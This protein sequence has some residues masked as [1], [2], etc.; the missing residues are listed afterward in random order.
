MNHPAFPFSRLPAPRSLLAHMPGIASGTNKMR[1]ISTRLACCFIVSMLAMLALL[2]PPAVHAQS[3]VT[4]CTEEALR[5]AIL[6]AIDADGL[7]VFDCDGIITLTNSISI[8]NENPGIPIELTF[9]AADHGVTISSLTGDNATNAVRLFFIAT[10]ASVEFINITF[11]N[12]RSTNGGAIYN[13][14]TNTFSSCVFSNNLATGTNGASAR[15]GSTNSSA[16]VGRDGSDGALGQAASGGAI[17]NWGTII[18][19]DCAFLTNS[20]IGG[21]GGDG[22]NAGAGRSLG[23]NGGSG[24]SGGY[25]YGGA[26]YNE[27]TKT[28]RGQAF[29]TN[30]TFKLN[31]AV[32]GSAG[33]GGAGGSGTIGGFSGSGGAGGGASGAAIYNRGNLRISSST[34]SLNDAF[35]GHSAASG[36][37][38][39]RGRAGSAGGESLGGGLCNLGLA[40]TANCTF[41][42][43]SA[44]GG[45]GGNGGNSGSLG[46]RGG[47]GGAAWG[48]N[49][50]SYISFFATNC[51]FTD[52]TVIAGTNAPGGSGSVAGPEG[53]R[54]VARGGN[55]A[56][57]KGTFYLRNSL[58]AL[59][60]RGT[61][62]YGSIVDGGFNLSTDRSIKF[63]KNSGSIIASNPGIDILAHNG[64]P[65]E[66]VALLEGSIAI[67]NGD[68]AFV[69]PVDARGVSRPALGTNSQRGDIGAYEAG[70]ALLT[71]RFLVQP[72]DRTVREFGT[73][74]FT[75]VAQGEAPIT[76]GWRKG[77]ADLGAGV[78]IG[79]STN[80][81]L[82]N[83]LTLFDVTD[84]EA[85]DYHV[86]AFNNSGSTQSKDA[87]LTVVHPPSFTL[88]LVSFTNDFGR[89][90]G[91]RVEVEG[92]APLTI[93]WY[94]DDALIPGAVLLDI[95]IPDPHF[96]ADY[97]AVVRN[98]YGR[99]TSEV[100]TVTILDR[101]PSI[102]TQPKNF[103]VALG[104]TATFTVEAGGSL[105]LY[106]RW[107][108]N[109]TNLV[110]AGD[111]KSTLSITNAQATQAGAYHVVISNVINTVTS[112]NVTL[113]VVTTRPTITSNPASLALPTGSTATFTVVAGGSAPFNYQWY[114]N[115][116]TILTGA[117]NST[118]TLTNI[119]T[120]NVGSY[121]VIIT[122]LVGSATSAPAVL[123]IQ[124]APPAIQ[125]QPTSTSVY[126]GNDLTLTV[127]A[128]GSNPLLY[129]WFFNSNLLTGAT[130]SSLTLTNAQVTTNGSYHVT[131]SNTLG[132][133]TSTVAT[134]TVSNLLP[135][136][137]VQPV[138]AIDA[139]VGST[140]TLSVTVV[141]S[142][143]LAYQWYRTEFVG[144]LPVA[145]TPVTDGT[146]SSLVFTD[147][148]DTESVPPLSIQGSYQVAI[149]NAFGGVVSDEVFFTVLGF[150]L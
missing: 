117:T 86:L 14:G 66:T 41:F 18:L 47:A 79:A 99:S 111:G 130:N 134:V 136:I 93:E 123:T 121:R 34:F 132:L 112:T 69:L 20:V 50:Y 138:D 63:R 109:G 61:N 80:T 54:G 100:A 24:R 5:A 58:V 15:H 137:T 144:G 19:N 110:L 101:P 6:E 81:V 143:P 135:T 10:N 141:G 2:S 32:G 88:D 131:I 113:T 146:N 120:T 102:T 104:K 25:A 21:N 53:R 4:E 98:Q 3:F 129:R 118:L 60:T 85:G 36:S 26:I 107:F 51:T 40:W 1:R 119:Q 78:T 11:A 65:V 73:V 77:T 133:A 96:T 142:V 8:T 38:S 95:I 140:V 9:D 64:G 43:N 35:G 45:D 57:A 75:V 87:T 116:N 82:T 125:S 150:G 76:F 46:G 71:P 12:G 33:V 49:V 28:L 91:L 56:R 115:T 89:D 29:I 108:R 90:F 122:N 126:S 106:Y 128:T 147:I 97:Y 145:T 68:P 42:G 139:T 149:T 70:L 55:L 83:S 92:T 114:F 39:S 17:F 72:S 67:N 7:V 22:G 74:T 127:A 30:T 103:V 31:L 52:G 48:G 44:T 59:P 148:G 23:G 105:P 37:R 62:F 16:L 13:L 84:E 27:A 124:S 94:K